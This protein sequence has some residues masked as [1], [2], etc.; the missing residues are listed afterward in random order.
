MKTFK[1]LSI[2][3]ITLLLSSCFSI[4]YD[5]KGGVTIHPDAK[6]F[7]VQY[8][9]NRA[10][11]V[12]PT[13]AQRLTD[14]LKDYIESGTDLKLDPNYGDIDF[15]GTITDY[16]IRSGAIVANDQAA[17]TRFTITVKVKMKNSADPDTDFEE[18]FSRYREFESTRNFDSG[19]EEELSD[20][21]I[22]ELLDLIFNKAFVN[23]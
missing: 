10:P 3:A 5:F 12:E 2:F 21:I 13:I 17:L 20:E 23:W 4:K 6:T 8:F 19:L 18:S 1:G 14:E 9:D 7:S 15:S 22:Q 16:S 11:R